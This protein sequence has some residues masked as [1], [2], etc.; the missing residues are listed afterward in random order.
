MKRKLLY[1]LSI[2]V[3]IF[4]GNAMLVGWTLT[5]VR[6]NTE[7][8]NVLFR[9]IDDM[10]QLYSAS[11]DAQLLLVEFQRGINRDINPLVD[12]I[13]ALEENLRR[14]S[15]HIREP[16]IRR[17]CIQCHNELPEKN[18]EELE[19][20]LSDIQLHLD[21]Y[22]SLISRLVTTSDPEVQN[23]MELQ[24]LDVSKE[25]IEI[26]GMLDRSSEAMIHHL[27]K[28]SALQVQSV[29]GLTFGA[30]VLS[31]LGAYWVVHRL[32]RII[33]TPLDTLKS[34]SEF[35]AQGLY[36][37]PV[38]IESRDEFE[39]LGNTFNQMVEKL[40]RTDMQKNELLLQTHRLNQALEKKA[41][42]V[43][44]KLEM[45]ENQLVRSQTL[46]A[47]GTLA[48]GV[49][50]E[51]SNPLGI[52]LGIASLAKKQL[53]DEDPLKEDL[54]S[55]ELEADRCQK[56]IR[57]LLDFARFK[58]VRFQPVDVNQILNETLD[59]VI[60]QKQYK[61][62][63]VVTEYEDGF[64]PVEADPNR[65]K[66]VFLNLFLNAAQATKN[67]GSLLIKTRK[68]ANGSKEAV[69]I[70][71]QDTGCGIPP[72]N[73][74][75]VFDPFFTTD[76]GSQGTGLGLSISHRIIEQHGGT[77][78]ARSQVG[79]GTTFTVRLP[80][81]ETCPGEMSDEKKTADR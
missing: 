42:D 26:S 41:D 25:I 32:T 33:I 78:S 50:H 11:L 9:G 21:E 65:L 28:K 15:L 59:L 17:T 8:I 55:I 3:L 76:K 67:E 27:V 54:R 58:E 70:D 77:I 30:V 6:A 5:R 56:I 75:R 61:K 4:A 80:V 19:P 39:L 12:R 14:S 69:V 79:T 64:S 16:H 2:L 29:F 36:P 40:R 44:R 13:I 37:P 46:Q 24:A 34:A 66:Q 35:V 38:K 81:T 18:W 60:H 72:E 31:I 63:Q 53:P 52:I 23:Q 68:D 71:V 74:N 73:L 47:V 57:G 10:S 7:V 22:K 49:S 51:I 45:T 1:H 20:H 43:T 62:M 48:A